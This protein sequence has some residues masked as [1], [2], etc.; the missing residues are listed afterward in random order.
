[1]TE[2]LKPLRLDHSVLAVSDWSASNQF[3]NDVLGAEIVPHGDP[4]RVAYRFGDTQ[5]NVPG[6]GV[7]VSTNVA[8]VPVQPATATSA[9]SGRGESPRRSPIFSRRAS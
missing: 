3:Y 9:S 2:G 6:P 5:L 7:D 1:M 8:R 4:P